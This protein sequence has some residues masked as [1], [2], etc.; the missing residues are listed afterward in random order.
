MRTRL[1]QLK[2]SRVTAGLLI[3][4]LLSRCIGALRAA[5]ELK[6][7]YNGRTLD[8]WVTRG[9]ANFEVEDGM[10][11]GKSDKGGHG[12]LC[13]KQNYGDFILELEVKLES[14]NSGVQI[15]S[16]I[17]DKDVMVGYQIE[18]DRSA[19][20]WSGGLY[21]QGRRKWLQDLADNGPAG[22]AFKPDEWNKYRI[23]CIGDSIKSWVNGV[24]ATDYVDSMDLDG[25]IALQVH[26]GKNTKVRFRN[27][28]LQDLGQHTWERIWDGKTSDGWHPIGRG[29]WKIADGVINGRHAQSEKEFGH[30]VTDAIYKDFTVRLKYKAVKGNSGLYFRIEE[31]GFSGVSGF[32]AE[33]DPEKD[34]GGLYETNGRAWVSQPK[35]DDVKKWYRANQWNTMT[36][37]A[38]GRRIVVNVNGFRTAE[39]R[40]D[41]GRTEGKLALQLHG[42]QDVEVYFKDIELLDKAK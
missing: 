17:N 13:S 32:Q 4:I 6:P 12:W 18:V 7:I 16:H 5:E 28:R 21:E 26:S 2:S 41:P 1:A 27:I 31:K 37:S 42:G 22:K 14:G 19:R 10:I 38:Q 30:L 33:I 15:R 40:D 29:D 25:L 24:P 11:V 8:G 35:P 3:L 9:G 23:V 20:A 34:A 39:L 36:V